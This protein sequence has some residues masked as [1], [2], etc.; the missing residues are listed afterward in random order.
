VRA[1][2]EELAQALAVQSRFR[3]AAVVE[4]VGHAPHRR[5][6][7]RVAVSEAEVRVGQAV[8]AQVLAGTCQHHHLRA[9]GVERARRGVGQR[10][11]ALDGT[12]LDGTV[13]ARPAREGRVRCQRD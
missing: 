10:H 5:A 11:A 9:A 12:G 4:L 1:V 8:L 2:E 13:F 3:A 6:L 7:R